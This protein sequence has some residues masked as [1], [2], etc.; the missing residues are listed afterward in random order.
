[1]SMKQHRKSKKDEKG[2]TRHMHNKL[3]YLMYILLDTYM[4][5]KPKYLIY[6]L[7]DTLFPYFNSS[8]MHLNE[9]GVQH[10]IKPAIISLLERCLGGAELWYA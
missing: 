5:N 1:M 6:G 9:I 7:L 2:R 8:F 3:K 10:K 4:Y